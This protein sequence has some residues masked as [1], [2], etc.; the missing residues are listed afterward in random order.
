M[1]NL[2]NLPVVV[3]A[4]SQVVAD[5]TIDNGTAGRK[6]IAHFWE[7]EYVYDKDRAEL[8]TKITKAIFS[9]DLKAVEALQEQI[10][11][12][13]KPQIIMIWKLL[14]PITKIKGTK[15]VYDGEKTYQPVMN[16]VTTLHISEDCVKLGLLEYEE[17]DQTMVDSH[18]KEAQVVILHL[19]K[20]IIDVKE[21]IRDRNNK[22]I[23]EARAAVTPISYKSMQVAGKIIR[24]EEDNKRK[25]FGFEE[26]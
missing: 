7:N 18:G 6:M 4:L 2:A 13:G 11:Q 3:Q 22:V 8:Q 5:S 14:E 26:N 1:K 25:L 15:V 12:L 23:R 10:A 21:A 24:L 16:N 17:T 9:R 19:K 20:G